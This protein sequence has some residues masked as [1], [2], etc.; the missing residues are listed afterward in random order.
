MNFI[1][2][3]LEATCW[4]GAPPNNVQEVIEIGAVRVNGYGEE[5]GTFNRFVKPLVNAQLSAFCTELTSIEQYQVNSAEL[6]PR[7]V[8]L[9]WDWADLDLDDYMLVSWG[10]EDQQ[11]LRNDCALHDLD[12]SWLAPHLN[13]KKAYRRLK[14]L[15]KYTGLM[16]TLEREGLEFDGTPHRAIYDAINTAKIFLKYRDEWPH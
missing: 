9:F 4:R 8:D 13:L 2:Y 3:D 12:D 16:K 6:F 5:I 1:I 11:L 14:R 15:S 10:K 7:V